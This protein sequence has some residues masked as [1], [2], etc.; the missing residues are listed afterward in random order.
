[1][2]LRQYFDTLRKWLWLI[3]LST[4][5]ATVASFLATRQ[6]APIYSASTTLMVGQTLENP[7]PT[8]NE[9]WLSQQ[10]AQTYAELA[11]RDTVKRAAMK[12]LNL[13]WLPE[14]TVSLVPNTQLL[15]I[16]VVDVDP[17]RSRDVANSLAN[18]L[19]LQSPSESDQDRQDRQLYVRQQ[20]DE[21]EENIDSTK[22]RIGE[23]QGDLSEMFSAR[24]IADTQ[25]QIFA[26][27]QKLNG[28]QAN[29]ASLLGFL[30]GGINTLRVVQEANLPATA[31][32]PQK[33]MTILLAAAIGL[34]LAVAAAYFLEYLDDTLKDPDDI[35]DAI[36]LSTLGAITRIEGEGPEEKL[37]TALQPKSPVSEAYR[38]LRTNIQFSALDD[39]P[40][41][42]L[43]TSSNP[44][45]GKSTTLANLGVVMAQQGQSVVIIDSD[46]RRP[47]QHRIFQV[48]NNAGLTN[49]LLQDKPS[50]TDFLQT[51]RIDNLKVLTSGPL[52]PNPA[53]LL[54][55]SR[56]RE[57][58][59]DMENQVDIVLLDSPPVLAVTDAAILGRQVDGV[60][61]IIDA[62]KTRRQ[63]AVSAKDSMEK[64]G[65]N[66]LGVVLNR[67]KPQG[68]G[69]YYYYY[70]RY[71]TYGEDGT[72]Q[73][74]RRRG[75]RRPRTDQAKA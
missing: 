54:G 33:M 40:K 71:Y 62:G 28:Y 18:Q 37:V 41:T 11:K 21:L 48:P 26:L 60:L 67:L 51:T 63:M 38:I 31:I 70:N 45:E 12:E 16:R 44:T 17:V 36:D 2:E 56:F 35:K 22:G 43:V 65:T 52:P 69:Y 20:L 47:V 46:L 6:Q 27:E 30:E 5:I 23:L 24:Q 64:I 75:P 7:N 3:L 13:S 39:P 29:Y 9:V 50:A 58:L 72:D 73:K 68:S 57:M 4:A 55:S 66:I 34:L 53:E 15:E 10:L 1:M 25:T 19:I 14:Y 32:G 74:K 8:G 59:K 42:L 49:A 61:L